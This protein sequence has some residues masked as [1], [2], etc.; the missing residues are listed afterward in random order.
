MNNEK[1]IQKSG[2]KT[3]SGEIGLDIRTHKN[4]KVGQDQVPGGVS[5][6]Y[7]HVKPVANALLK[8]FEKW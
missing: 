7:G 4:P 5:V 8:P 3:S 1:Q 6:P 2:D